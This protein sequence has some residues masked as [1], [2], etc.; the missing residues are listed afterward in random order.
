M[1]FQECKPAIYCISFVVTMFIVKN[2]SFPK[3][4]KKREE[5]LD[6]VCVGAKILTDIETS[7]DFINIYS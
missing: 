2:S 5:W 7:I 6:S 1:D 4:F 3:L